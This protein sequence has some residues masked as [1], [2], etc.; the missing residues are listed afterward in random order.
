MRNYL[1]AYSAA[2]SRR[3][4]GRD[5]IGYDDKSGA[6][7]HKNCTDLLDSKGRRYERRKDEHDRYSKS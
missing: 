6:S 4:H 2:R 1:Q 7:G 5:F 3:D